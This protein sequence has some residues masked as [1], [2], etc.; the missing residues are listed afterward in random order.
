M[1]ASRIIAFV[2]TLLAATFTIATVV[3]D[4]SAIANGQTFDFV[5]VGAGLA[6]LTVANKVPSARKRLVGHFLTR[7][8]AERAELQY[9]R[10]G[11]RSRRFMEQ[12]SQVRWEHQLSAHLLQSKLSAI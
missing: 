10:H 9:T 12:C 8:L 1:R 5:I 7:I 3:T 4:Q 2:G 6:G 11:G